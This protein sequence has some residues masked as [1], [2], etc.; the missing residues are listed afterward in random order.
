M[1]L[2]YFFNSQVS[3]E[4]F[5]AFV[6]GVAGLA[7]V[8]GGAIAQRPPLHPVFA[9]QAIAHVKTVDR[10]AEDVLVPED[11]VGGVACP[12]RRGLARDVNG[13]AHHSHHL[14]SSGT[15]LYKKNIPLFF[16]SMNLDSS[17]ILT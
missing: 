17:M 16:A 14:T 11:E 12:G 15:F 9:G 8:E 1:F 3:F 7:D 6:R 10:R 4:L 2:S 5:G 13:L